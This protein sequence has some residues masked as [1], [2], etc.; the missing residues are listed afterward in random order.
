M[1][2]PFKV[3]PP[4][5][6]LHQCVDVHELSAILGTNYNQLSKLIYP[7][8]QNSYYCFSIDKMNGN[9]RVINA[10][11]NK[12]KSIQR[13]L[14]YLLNEYYPVR[15][16]A[17]GF[18]KN[19][20]I[21]SNAEQH[22]LKNCV[23]NIDLENFFGQIHFGRIR[24]LLF[25]PPFNFSTSVSTVISHICCSDGFLPQG[26]PTSPIISNLICYKLD[27]ELRRL[28]VYHKCT[29]TRYVDDIT[30]SFTCKANRIPSQIVVSSGNTVT[31]GN[32][33]NAIITR[34][35]FSINDKKTRLQQKN[36]RQIVTGIVVNKRTNVQRSFVRKTNSMLYAWEKFGAILAEKDYFDKYNSK[37]KTIKL[38][39][40][41]DNPGELF[42]SI[43]KGRINYIKMVRGKDDVIY[44]KFAHRISCL[45]GKF[46]NRYLKTPYD[47]AIESTFVLENRCDDSQGTAF[48]LE[49]IGL[50]TNHHVVEDICDIT[51]EFIDLFLWNEIGNIRKTKFIMSNKLF[52][53]A[54]F[55][56]TSDFD[57]ITPLKIGDDSGIKNG[58]VITVIGFPQYSPGESAYVNTGKVIQS[59]TMYGNKFWLIDIPVI[60][61]NSG[62]PVLNDK[63]EVIGIASIGTA[64]N[65]S[66]S[67]LHGFIPISTL[68]RYTGEDK[69]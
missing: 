51:D 9:K 6:K 13:R 48:L 28:A 40:F 35:G 33:I 38:K 44:R 39:D 52:D 8:T 45:F 17:H 25:S 23:F 58:T 32:E 34:N 53:I 16:V 11:K 62:G 14:A 56:R 26:A 54:V 59:K 10:P 21:V 18:I 31:P 49:R 41:I 60:H 61:G 55:E 5:L 7:T 64:K 2:D 27:N 15:D 36:E 67:K 47:F 24:N 50:V 20:S 37:I 1:F 42:K 4:K 12:L 63:F 65:D 46:D 69:P 43:V 57:N 22:V 3:A 19:K 30:F 68:L 66:S 29:Y